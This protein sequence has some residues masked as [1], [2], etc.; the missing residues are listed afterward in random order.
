MKDK[1]VIRD[2]NFVKAQILDVIAY[3]Q[4]KCIF[5]EN[6]YVIFIKDDKS[7]TIN[8]QTKRFVATKQKD[9]T[10]KT[11]GFSSVENRLNRATD[12]FYS[13]IISNNVRT[14]TFNHII[15]FTNQTYYDYVIEYLS[16]LNEKIEAKKA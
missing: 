7:R 8:I 15:K 11:L 12:V 5:T 2:K 6:D 10:L 1:E 16:E 4:K 13:C 9:G 3:M 14:K